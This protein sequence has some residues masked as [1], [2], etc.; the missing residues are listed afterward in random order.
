M[1]GLTGD[2]S[3]MPLKDLVV[4]L[5]N[6]MA[7]GTLT[8]EHGTI[9]KQAVLDEGQVV[10][11]SSNVPRE[12]LG[13]FL[14][15]LGHINEEQFQR[16]WATQQETKVFLGRILLMIGLITEENLTAVLQLKFRETL[17]EAFD[18]KDGT[19]AFE[20]GVTPNLPDGAQVRLPLVDVHKEADFRVR[21][22]QHFRRAFPRGSCTVTLKRENLAEP[23]RPGSMDEKVLHFIEDGMTLEEI[24][25]RTHATDFFLYNRLY[26]LYRLGALIVHD[27]AEDFEIDVELGLGDNPTPEQLLEHARKFYEQGNLRDAWALSRRANQLTPSL[28]AALLQRQV[29]VAW[30]PKLK[31]SLIASGKKPAIALSA[32][33]LARL[34]LSASERYLISRVDGRRTVEN[35]IRVA[36][37][38]ELE[39]LAFV[40]RFVAQKWVS[41]P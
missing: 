4:Y 37:L 19:F 35:I 15:N 29:E 8:L 13:Q 16:A 14:I 31:A 39:A 30:L 22:W 34:P 27:G 18:W 26:A 28:D 25:L 11:A 36:P 17:L 24:G 38:S 32:G 41:L 7:T 21:A 20:A 9:I 1:R 23:P 10:N 40:D 2:F 33:E 6:R 5:A 12:F 3:T